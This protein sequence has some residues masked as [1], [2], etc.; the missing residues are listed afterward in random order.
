M[1]SRARSP[2]VPSSIEKLREAVR[3]TCVNRAQDAENKAFEEKVIDALVEK[4]QLAFPPLLV[5]RKS[6]A[7]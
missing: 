6:S 4:S 1:I 5:D 2:P 3:E 7:W